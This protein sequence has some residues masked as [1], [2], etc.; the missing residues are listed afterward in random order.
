MLDLVAYY[1]I[2]V[3]KILVLVLVPETGDLDMFVPFSVI[4]PLRFLQ[5]S[6]RSTRELVVCVGMQGSARDHKNGWNTLSDGWRCRHFWL[7]N[8]FSFA[9]VLTPRKPLL[10]Q[11]FP[12]VINSPGM[13]SAPPFLQ[14]CPINFFFFKF[15]E[16]LPGAWPGHKLS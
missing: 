2:W 9:I 16:P 15:K 1:S 7:K 14:S 5:R 13:P 4:H 12:G 8:Q 3:E 10:L 6:L 11:V